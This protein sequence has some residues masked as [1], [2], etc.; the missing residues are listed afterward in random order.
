[1]IMTVNE[2]IEK[3]ASAPESISFQGTMDVI[4]E[5]YDYSPTRFTNGLEDD[6]VEN[7]AGSNEGSCKIFAFAKLNG[8]SEAQTLTC[9]GD[10]YRDDVLKNPQGT[11]HANIRTFMRHGWAGIAFDGEALVAK[12]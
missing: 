6:Q 8:L 3:T 12:S 9:F 10:F 7:L 11:D 5:Y 1:M 2:F 4:S